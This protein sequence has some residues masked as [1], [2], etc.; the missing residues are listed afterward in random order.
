MEQPLD[1]SMPGIDYCF[2]S[3]EDPDTVR[4]LTEAT[5]HF[6]SLHCGVPD[7]LI[8]DF[9]R[10]LTTLPASQ[11][12]GLPYGP[13][14]VTLCSPYDAPAEFQGVAVTPNMVICVRKNVSFVDEV[15]TTESIVASTGEI[16]G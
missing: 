1:S 14:H 11:W 5:E 9:W 8:M 13:V 3:S 12:H 2:Y 4:L 7:I 16:H 15:E 10:R 6:G